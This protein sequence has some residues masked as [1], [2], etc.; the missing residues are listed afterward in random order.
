M[1]TDQA[2]KQ[3]VERENVGLLVCVL[4][5][6]RSQQDEEYQCSLVIDRGR[7]RKYRHIHMASSHSTK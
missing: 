7:V 1:F 6:L 5:A 2:D 4:R 3:A